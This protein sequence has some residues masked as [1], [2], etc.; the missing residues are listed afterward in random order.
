MP[1]Y[2]EELCHLASAEKLSQALT[3]RGRSGWI[4]ALVTTRLQRLPEEQAEVVRAAAVVGTVVPYRSLIAACGHA[5]D[6]ETL[7]AL[8]DADFLFV[9][10]ASGGLRFKHGIT[11]DSI[12]ESIGL[13]MRRTLHRRIAAAHMSRGPGLDHD[14]TLE[15]LAYHSFGAADWDKAAQF[16]E[17]AGDK[18]TVAFALDR[19]RALQSRH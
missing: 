16:A 1:L 10:P 17:Q 5:P 3:E 7:R 13:T 15:A 8:A 11:R 9:D 6:E 19:A 14:D 4:G 12:Y 18:A 2:I